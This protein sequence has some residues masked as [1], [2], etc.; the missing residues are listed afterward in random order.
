[1]TWRTSGAGLRS[2]R[3]PAGSRNTPRAASAAPSSAS[4][5]GTVRRTQHDARDG[6]APRT[7]QVGADVSDV[8]P[9]GG[10]A[11]RLLLVLAPDRTGRLVPQWGPRRAPRAH[12]GDPSAQ[13]A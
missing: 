1:M 9:R 2:A 12:A 7:R 3:P 10:H 8:W 11:L 4:A 13:P 6:P 5:P